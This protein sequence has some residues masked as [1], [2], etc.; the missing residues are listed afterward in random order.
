MNSALRTFIIYA[1]GLFALAGIYLAADLYG[2][3]MPFNNLSPLEEGL[4]RRGLLGDAAVG[5]LVHLM[6]FLST[7][8]RVRSSAKFFYALYLLQLLYHGPYTVLQLA[9]SSAM[10]GRLKTDVIRKNGLVVL[11]MAASNAVGAFLL[12]ERQSNNKHLNGKTD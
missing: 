11:A 12:V 6:V 4:E 7:E 5:L 10:E 9:E 1:P 3:S 8:S 2:S